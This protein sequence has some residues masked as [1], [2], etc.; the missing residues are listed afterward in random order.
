MEPMRVHNLYNSNKER[1]DAVIDILNKVGLSEDYFNRYPHEFSGGQRQRIGIARTIALQPKLI[2]CDESVSA[3][4]ISVQAQVL[5]LL[6]DLKE[7]F[8]FTYIFISHDLAVV[9]Y[10]SDQLLVMNEGKIEELDDADVIYCNPKKEY[11][12]KLIHAIPKGL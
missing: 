1:K 6:N 5:N 3:L 12:K 2:V 10:M 7:T 9:K 8:G 4:D 11:T